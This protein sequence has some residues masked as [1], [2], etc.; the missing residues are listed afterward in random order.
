MSLGR[1]PGFT[2]TLPPPSPNSNEKHLFPFYHRHCVSGMGMG[3]GNPEPPA[4]GEMDDNSLSPEACY[5][6][7][8]NGYPKRGRKRRSANETDASNIEVGQKVVSP[9][10]SYCRKVLQIP[11]VSSKDAPKWEESP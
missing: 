6:C 5:E 11:M 10:V 8:I 2:R 3:R 1:G 9:D 4:S 7:K